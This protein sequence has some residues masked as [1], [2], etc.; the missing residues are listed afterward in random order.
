MIRSSLPNTKNSTF[1]VLVPH[2]DSRLQG[3]PTPNGTGFFVTKDGYFITARHVLEKESVNRTLYNS[4]EILLTKAEQPAWDVSKLSIVKDWPKWDLALL[5][6][7]CEK[8]KSSVAFRGKDGFDFL[9]IPG[10]VRAL[11]GALL[12]RTRAVSVSSYRDNR[13]VDS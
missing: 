4:S 6:A 5:R 9:E 1:T 13:S 7:D 3:F 2:P 10:A 8:S 11:S 12:L